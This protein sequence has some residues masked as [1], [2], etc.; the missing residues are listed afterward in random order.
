MANNR[1]LYV[2]WPVGEAGMLVL[3]ATR[4]LRNARNAP[5]KPNKEPK[6]WRLVYFVPGQDCLSALQMSDQIYVLG[7]G[8]PGSSRISIDSSA[9]QTARFDLVCNRLQDNG[10]KKHFAGKIKF[11]NC[12]GALDFE[13]N[14]GPE[15]F[16]AKSARLLRERGFTECRI[17]GYSTPVSNPDKSG[18]KSRERT[19]AGYPRPVWV[20]GARGSRVEFGQNG[21]ILLFPDRKPIVPLPFVEGADEE[22]LI[23]DDP[24]D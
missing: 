14:V 15:S 7:H 22:E 5:A 1:I 3:M 11:Y 6:T 17:F 4:F 18:K 2:P 23:E 24:G 8:L 20:P 10:L 16:A 19:I 21:E 13:S 12:S 9:S